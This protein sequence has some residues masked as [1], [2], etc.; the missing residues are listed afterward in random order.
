MTSDE[1]SD[2]IGYLRQLWP[3]WSPSATEINLWHE[4]LD[5]KPYHAT[6]KAIGQWYKGAEVPGKKPT[7]GKISKILPRTI[8]ANEQQQP[9]E[10]FYLQKEN[11]YKKHYFSQPGN[12]AKPDQHEIE[13][14]AGK[15]KAQYEDMYGDTYLIHYC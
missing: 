5:N 14:Y 15:M 6:R 4:V 7:I 10:L 3:D 1:K 9:I 11:S 13:Q 8:N 2:I 12:K